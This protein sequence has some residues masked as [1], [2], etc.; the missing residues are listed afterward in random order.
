M[1][2]A[3]VSMVDSGS[4]IQPKNKLKREEINII[5]ISFSK[6]VLIHIF[7]LRSI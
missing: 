4:K 1:L 7:H 3:S 2:G 5:L 6:I